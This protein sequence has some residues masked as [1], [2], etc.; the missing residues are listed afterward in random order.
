MQNPA[1]V[2]QRWSFAFPTIPVAMPISRTQVEIGPHRAQPL[3]GET[4]GHTGVDAMMGGLSILAVGLV[5]GVAIA[6]VLPGLPRLLPSVAARAAPRAEKPAGEPDPCAGPKNDQPSLVKLDA[7]DA[8][9]VRDDG[10]GDDNPTGYGTASDRSQCDTGR[11]DGAHVGVKSSSIGCRAAKKYRRTGGNSFW[12]RIA[13]MSWTDFFESKGFGACFGGL[14][15][16]VTL[17]MAGVNARSTFALTLL[18][19]VGYWLAFDK[20]R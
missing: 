4:V 6:W 2:A 13:M 9:R 20:P 19:V 10:T 14:V 8:V 7:N 1:R 3:G 18:I 17:Q 11:L 15:S 5:I 12:G 16:A